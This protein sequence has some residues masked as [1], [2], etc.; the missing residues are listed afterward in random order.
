M[1][2]SGIQNIKNMYNKLNY[3][4]Q[5]GAS[6]LLFIIITIILFILISYCFV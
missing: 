4:D 2:H 3:F 5:Y 1:D 6:V